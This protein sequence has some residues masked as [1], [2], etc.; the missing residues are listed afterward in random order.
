M[1][2]QSADILIFHHFLYG[3]SFRRYAYL[4]PV[5]FSLTIYRFGNCLCFHQVKK[6][7]T[8]GAESIAWS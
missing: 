1:A 4:P 2:M 7:E 8:K 5:V 6:S 3:D